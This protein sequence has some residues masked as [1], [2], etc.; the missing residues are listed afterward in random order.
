MLARD[1][2][3]P[4]PEECIFM[5]IVVNFIKELIGVCQTAIQGP[6]E[7]DD[8]SW[9]DQV[10]EMAAKNNLKVIMCTP[11]P[12]PPAWLTQKHPEILAVDKGLYRQQHG[13]RLHVIYNHPVYLQYVE[14]II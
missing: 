6:M 11:T 1:V 4:L 10:V 13:G 5:D 12:T 8:S 9:L 3:N 2:F 14:N 7:I